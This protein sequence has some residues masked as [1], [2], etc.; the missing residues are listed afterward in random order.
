MTTLRPATP[1]DAAA[2]AALGTDA[3][4]EKFGHLY[5]PEDLKLFLDEYRTEAAY[6]TQLADP[7]TSIQLAEADGKLLGYCLII[8]GDSFDERPDPQPA[9]PVI[10]SQLYCAPSATGRGI[11]S[12]LTE[13]AI[14]E[15]KAWGADALQLSVYAENFGAHKFYHRHGFAKVADMGF[16]VGNH[17]DDEFLYELKL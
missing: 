17:R 16:W 9:R 10:L 4:I 11:G 14:A 8:R 6:R 2:I 13:W 7:G 5:K 1:D 3:F 15:A 12:R